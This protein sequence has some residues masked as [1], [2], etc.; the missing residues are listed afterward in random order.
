M[1]TKFYGTSLSRAIKAA[2]EQNL[3]PKDII[4]ISNTRF[5]SA[6]HMAEVYG[7]GGNSWAAS[8]SKEETEYAKRVW[9]EGIIAQPRLHMHSVF[10]YS[11]GYRELVGVASGPAELGTDADTSVCLKSTGYLI[12]DI[13]QLITSEK[14][15]E[16]IAILQEAG[17]LPEFKNE[18]GK[19]ISLDE[20]MLQNQE[21]TKS[22]IVISSEDIT[23]YYKGDVSSPTPEVHVPPNVT[24]INIKNANVVFIPET[25]NDI[26]YNA[27]FN[28]L[29]CQ[30][31]TQRD[32][33]DLT[34]DSG[35]FMT[36]TDYDKFVDSGMTDP[37]EFMR[38]EYAPFLYN[39]N[40]EIIAIRGVYKE[41]I[42]QLE[43]P[44]NTAIN[45][46]EL[47]SSL[48]DCPNLEFIIDN[49]KQLSL[50]EFARM[51]DPQPAD[52]SKDGTIVY[53]VKP[54]YKD[55]DTLTLP[56]SVESF[57]YSA[58]RDSNVQTIIT[59]NPNFDI[60]DPFKLPCKEDSEIKISIAG[61][62]PQNLVDMIKENHSGFRMLDGEVYELHHLYHDEEILK[63]PEGATHCDYDVFRN[64][65]NKILYLPST[66]E[67]LDGKIISH[68]IETII[69]H[70]NTTDIKLS[71]NLLYYR[72]H[73]TIVCSDEIKEQLIKQYSEFP[74]HPGIH[75]KEPTILTY[76]EYAEATKDMSPNTDALT[77]AET[78][79]HLSNEKS[80]TSHAELE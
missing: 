37:K 61:A 67:T 9:E 72:E 39:E 68:S 62:E 25:V 3:D 75:M 30:N 78:E 7:P 70:E 60:G 57:G 35:V 53:G 31:E 14:D 11:N 59:N 58:F 28:I 18:T 65:N 13:K 63:I 49:G 74:V 80:N 38:N 2:Y 29:V 64:A 8:W 54:Y 10:E 32:S 79:D 20:Y 12:S 43:I 22:Y 27:N 33:I 26:S 21:S 34:S 77:L 52:I 24:N 40:N 44:E 16:L 19:T 76:E 17:A 1:S 46:K 73:P 36:K 41:T 69:L 56:D 50:D 71:E 47:Y 4:I 42:T 51:H 66:F 48:K 45:I 23:F 5:D 15:K 6:E 55:I